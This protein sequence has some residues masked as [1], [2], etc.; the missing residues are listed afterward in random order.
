MI[1][2]LSCKLLLLASLTACGAPGSDLVFTRGNPKTPTPD[3]ASK[4]AANPDAPPRARIAFLPT[5]GLYRRIGDDSRF[6]PCGTR[7]LL[8]VGGSGEGRFLL[9]QHFRFNAVWMG[10][11]LYG[12]LRGAV[13]TETLPPRPAAKGADTLPTIRTRFYVVGVDSLRT[14]LPG[15]CNGMKVPG[16]E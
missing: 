8:Q 6:Q 16:P 5:K 1:R 9:A 10:R 3:S 2:K 12:I 15:D 4:A 13:I 14:W 11:P 7:E